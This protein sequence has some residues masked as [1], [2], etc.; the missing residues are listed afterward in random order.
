MD[1]CADVLINAMRSEDVSTENIPYREWCTKE[2]LA[3]K[4]AFRS[5][6]N[7]LIKENKIGK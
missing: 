2:H 1:E 5:H 7:K 6:L 4:E 3:I